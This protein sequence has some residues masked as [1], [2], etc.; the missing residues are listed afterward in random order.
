MV[1]VGPMSRSEPKVRLGFLKKVK[2]H[3]ELSVHRHHPIRRKSQ[4]LGHP[5][6]IIFSSSVFLI[7]ALSVWVE[8][9][10]RHLLVEVRL[11]TQPR[12]RWAHM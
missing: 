7:F 1:T 4:I 12:C 2:E 5:C 11:G 6:I 3:S 10:L 8:I 9:H